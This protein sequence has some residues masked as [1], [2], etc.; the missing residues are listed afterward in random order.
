MQIAGQGDLEA[1]HPGGQL[2]GDDLQPHW[3][4]LGGR[5]AGVSAEQKGD[6]QGKGHRATPAFGLADAAAHLAQK[7]PG[8]ADQVQDQKAGQAQE[9]EAHPVIAHPAQGAGQ[10]GLPHG[11]CQLGEHRGQDHEDEPAPEE[12]AGAGAPGQQAA[13]RQVIQEVQAGVY[14][15]ED[16][17]EPSHGVSLL[18]MREARMRS[19]TRDMNK[20]SI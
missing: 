4:D 20:G 5:P 2:V 13:H 12:Q 18:K 6:G 14:R 1:C 8:Q 16:D 17:Q 15:Q 10:A 7:P 9:H 11:T 19:G 3:A